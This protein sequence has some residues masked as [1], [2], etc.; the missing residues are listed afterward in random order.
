MS[1]YIG[2]S[3]S[4]KD[5]VVAA[6]LHSATRNIPIV[7]VLTAHPIAE[8]WATSLA[9]HGGNITGFLATENEIVSASVS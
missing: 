8:G 9:H 3:A 2:M 7:F 1:I 4:R 5:D 6:A